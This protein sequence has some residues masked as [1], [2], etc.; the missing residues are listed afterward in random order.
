MNKLL[1]CCD[2]FRELKRSVGKEGMD[3]SV[4]SFRSLSMGDIERQ[5][6][7]RLET[8]SMRTLTTAHCLISCFTLSLRLV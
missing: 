1:R 5:E 8:L 7:F 4:F 2:M 3:V 6:E